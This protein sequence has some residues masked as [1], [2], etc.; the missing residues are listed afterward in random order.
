VA[1]VVVVEDEADIA[2]L[3][4]TKFRNAG[5]DVTLARDGEQGLRLVTETAPDVVLL[6]VMMPKLDGYT[7]CERIRRQFGAGTPLVVLLS[8][9]SQASDRQRGFDAGCDEYVTKPFRPADLLAR[10]TEL[11]HQ[12]GIA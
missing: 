3:V 7:V 9:R 1:R 11:M 2:T 5:H 10:V 12:R 8:A 6:D 4:L